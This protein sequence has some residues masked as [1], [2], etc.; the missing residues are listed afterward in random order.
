[1]Y[2]LDVSKKKKT[3]KKPP[4]LEFAGATQRKS[5]RLQPFPNRVVPPLEPH[6]EA[7]QLYT[8][9]THFTLSLCVR[10]GMRRGYVTVKYR[11][12]TGPRLHLHRHPFE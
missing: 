1:M 3:T 7:V 9:H 6:S 2:L 12:S 10:E 11:I 8:R 4:I 5:K